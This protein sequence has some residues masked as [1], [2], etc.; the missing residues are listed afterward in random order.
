MILAC[1]Q[2]AESELS[3]NCASRTSTEGEHFISEKEGKGFSFF[4]PNLRAEDINESQSNDS[5]AMPKMC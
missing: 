3:S 1:I 4:F 5:C 2:S